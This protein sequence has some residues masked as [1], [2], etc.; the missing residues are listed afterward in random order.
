MFVRLSLAAALALSA[1]IVTVSAADLET[2]APDK[3]A[4]AVARPNGFA[5]LHGG[6]ADMRGEDLSAIVAGG[7]SIAIPL[8]CLVG[9]Q[10]DIKAEHQF[11][12]ESANITLHTFVRDPDAYLL[13]IIGGYGDF[14]A[15]DAWYVGPEFELY[16][17][18][19]SFEATAGY[20]NVLDGPR[21][22]DQVF[23]LADVAFYPTENLRLVAGVSS[24]AKFESA[25]VGLEWSMQDHGLPIS[26]TLDGRA[27]ERD[28][29]QATAGLKI[30]FGGETKS[31]IR[32]H[33]EDAARNRALDLNF[34][35][36]GTTGF[37][38]GDGDS[39]TPPGQTPPPPEPNP[40]PNPPPGQNPPP[41]AP[42][43]PEPDPTIEELK[44]AIGTKCSSRLFDALVN[45]IGSD[46]MFRDENGICL[47]RS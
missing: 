35:A 27:G 15:T 20:M 28:Y 8:G 6:V 26:M 22:G 43:P 16:G 42:N 14:G 34:A 12:D 32:R 1:S 44:N 47:D 38:L 4:C 19:A 30:Y 10:L 46:R 3:A 25:H 41:P 29:I 37:G 39:S 5:E 11:S 2:S 45:L 17:E 36:G 13:G 24:V 31:L 40:T 7:A 33:R 9:A 23:A 21:E 18:R